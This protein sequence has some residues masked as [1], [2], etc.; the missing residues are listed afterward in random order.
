MNVRWEVIVEVLVKF[1][2]G[3]IKHNN[4]PRRQLKVVDLMLEKGKG[5][6][7]KKLRMLEMIEVDLQLVMRMHLGSK[8]NE[9]VESDV[10]L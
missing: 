9:R 10:R 4:Y 1:Y 8:M 5:P 6:R 3:F 7:L 2:N